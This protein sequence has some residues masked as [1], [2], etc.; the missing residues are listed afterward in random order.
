[1]IK[2]AAI[3]EGYGDVAAMPTL[4]AKAAAMFDKTDIASNPIR[5][6]EWAGLS[7]NGEFEKHL[8]LAARREC[9]LILTVLDLDDGCPVEN[10]ALARQRIDNWRG[11]RSVRSE[12]VFLPREYETLFLLAP[13]CFGTFDERLIP[14]NPD[15]I[16]GAKERI[17]PIIGRRYKETQDQLS[18][19][20]KVDTF[21]LYHNS[22]TFRRLC[23]ALLNV[24]YNQMD[25]LIG[26]GA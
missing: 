19:T 10:V 11:T 2:V 9:D 25:G 6:G 14:S 22:K 3:V 18:F 24:S 5:A 1:V 15:S 8:E 23:K 7:R 4:I 16:R 12:I 17:K 26:A 13:S 21:E 20:K